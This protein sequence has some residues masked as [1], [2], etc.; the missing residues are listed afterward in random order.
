MVPKIFPFGLWQWLSPWQ[1]LLP[2]GQAVSVTNLH[3]QLMPHSHFFLNL[4]LKTE[5]AEL[6]NC[7]YKALISK[8]LF[9]SSAHVQNL[10][11]WCKLG[12]KFYFWWVLRQLHADIYYYKIINAPLL[13]NTEYQK[14]CHWIKTWKEDTSLQIKHWHLFREFLL[15]R[16]KNG[17]VLSL[18]CLKNYFSPP[19]W[20]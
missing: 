8:W 17:T 7:G 1:R 5:G 16:E 15:K 9:P 20:N 6:D 11:R 13:S 12:W 14:W 3:R 4:E 19:K 18:S 10:Q 2:P